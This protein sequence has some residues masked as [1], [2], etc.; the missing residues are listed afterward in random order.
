MAMKRLRKVGKLQGE[1]QFALRSTSRIQS[2]IQLSDEMSSQ[3]GTRTKEK[4]KE[5][6][7]TAYVSRFRLTLC[8]SVQTSYRILN[9]NAVRSL[10]S[11]EAVMAVCCRLSAIKVSA[12]TGT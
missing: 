6:P 9:V 1:D 4:E 12:I 7:V 3:A 5:K 2:L 8:E 10:S 11:I